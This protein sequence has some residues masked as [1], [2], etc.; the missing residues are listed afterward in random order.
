MTE[1]Q[2]VDLLNRLEGLRCQLSTFMDTV[3]SE[4]E[5]SRS[6]QRDILAAM[7]PCKRKHR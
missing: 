2:M 6:R 7:L 1:A 5:A 4:L 3:N